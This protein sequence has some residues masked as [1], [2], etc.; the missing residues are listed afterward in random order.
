MALWAKKQYGYW[1]YKRGFQYPNLNF[2]FH[3]GPP[4]GPWLSRLC[5]ATVRN[6][7]ICAVSVGIAI[8]ALPIADAHNDAEDIPRRR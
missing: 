1:D 2:N 3:T 8:I 7:L 5:N 6:K 4:L